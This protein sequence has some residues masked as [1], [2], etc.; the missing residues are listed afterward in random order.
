MIGHESLEYL[1]QNLCEQGPPHPRLQ[2]LNPAEGGVVEPQRS[3]DGEKQFL[4]LNGFGHGF[5]LRARVSSGHVAVLPR[6][7]MNSRRLT[8]RPSLGIGKIGPNDITPHRGS[9]VGTLSGE[10]K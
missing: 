9:G 7:A 4:L 1:R 2:I 5:R 3:I 10:E 6:A 8:R